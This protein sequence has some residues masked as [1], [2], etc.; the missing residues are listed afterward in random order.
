MSRQE[1]LDEVQQKIVAD[2]VVDPRET[3]RNVL[4]VIASY[5]GAGEMEKVM[6]SFPQDM[7]S[8]FPA[9]APAA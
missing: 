2:R 1:F 6:L 8:L 4:S 9:L 5:I 7:R 3:T